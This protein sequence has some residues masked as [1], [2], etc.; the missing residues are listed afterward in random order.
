MSDRVRATP[1]SWGRAAESFD[2]A[3]VG[4]ASVLGD[5]VSVTTDP[6]A[7]G[8][9]EGLATVDGAVAMMLGVFGSVMLDCVISPLGEGLAGE[10]AAMAATGV[11]LR[12]MEEFA[13]DQARGI[14]Q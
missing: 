9:A 4:A 14:W 12:E 8:A 11:S 7:C 6:G 5:L 1:G 13:E 3:G 10:A 2:G